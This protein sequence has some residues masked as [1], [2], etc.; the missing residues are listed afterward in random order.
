[1][2][3]ARYLGFRVGRLTPG[4]AELIQ[5]YRKELTQGDGYFQG[6]VLGS[7]ADFAGERRREP[8]CRRDG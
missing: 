8:S 6:G 4:E 1:M 5:P 3:A 2:P 7:L